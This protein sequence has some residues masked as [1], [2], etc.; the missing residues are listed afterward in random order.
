MWCVIWKCGSLLTSC[1]PQ[2]HLRNSSVG[3]NKQDVQF[4]FNTREVTRLADPGPCAWAGWGDWP[5]G[6]CAWGLG[7]GERGAYEISVLYLALEFCIS[8]TSLLAGSGEVSMWTAWIF[9][10][11]FWSVLV[12]HCPNA[13]LN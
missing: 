4:T 8:S 6:Y 1:P 3:G 10:V 2:L 11:V 7:E 9:P 12:R 5:C 13:S